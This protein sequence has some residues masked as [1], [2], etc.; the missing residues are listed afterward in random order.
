MSV[1]S[2]IV[3]GAQLPI[4]PSTTIAVVIPCYWVARDV[5]GVL[6][7]MPPQVSA[8]YC[9]DDSCPQ[10]SGDLIEQ[11][12]RDPRV[13]VLRHAINTGV[14]GAVVTGYRQ[15]IADG[16][17]IVVKVDGDGQ[18]N[19]ALIMPLIRP[20]AAG[21]A[22][23]A[24]GNRFWNVSGVKMMPRSRLA[25]NAILSFVTKFSTSYWN[26]FDPTN[27]FTA[28]HSA[29]LQALPLDKISMRFLLRE[30][31][32]FPFGDNP[33]GRGRCPDDCS[34]SRRHGQQFED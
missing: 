6:A 7:A 32:A 31:P 15:A 14:G 13:R 21:T 5:L 9:V 19:P 8:I 28:I 18:M 23:Y 34:L 26:V 29:V 30:R 1:E 24:K 2:T 11:E 4:A 22:D 12:C 20:I 27:G 33:G 17:D 16:W 25:G 10:R 3:D